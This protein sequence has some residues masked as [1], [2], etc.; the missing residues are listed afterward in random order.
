MKGIFKTAF[1][2][3]AM[4]FAVAC[5]GQNQ[6]GG[7]KEMIRLNVT[8]AAD[9]EHLGEVIDG[10]NRM[11][12]ESQRE[13]GCIGYDIYQSTSDPHRLI[14]VETW[15]DQAALDAHA[16]TPHYTTILPALKGKMKTELERFEF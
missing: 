5:C 16:L 13:D 1:A 14:I 6:Q 11:A 3:A 2:A 12:A 15:A 7:E 8:V 9:P 4:A 10:L